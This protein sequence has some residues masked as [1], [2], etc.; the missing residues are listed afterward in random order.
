MIAVLFEVEP[1]HAQRDNYFM[2]AKNL[3]DI[4]LEA[5]GFISIERFQSLSD[6]SRILSLSFWENEEAVLAW[7][8]QRQHIEA[9][10]IGKASIF[11]NYR[12][13]VATVIRDYKMSSS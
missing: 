9:Q 3:K 4:L 7:K 1:K 10:A 12:I 11:Q 13:R 6:A 2:L 5:R 8:D